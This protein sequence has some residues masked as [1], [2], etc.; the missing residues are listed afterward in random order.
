VSTHRLYSQV[1]KEV[2]GDGRVD[3]QV[4]I[5]GARQHAKDYIGFDMNQ[6]A[7]DTGCVISAIL[8]GAL[9][10]CERLP[11]KREQ[12][13]QVI[14]ESGKAVESNLAGFNAGYRQAQESLDTAN[15]A[16][17]H[18]PKAE[19]QNSYVF[20]TAANQ[21]LQTLLTQVETTLPSAAHEFTVAGIK[22][23]I[24]YQDLDYAIEY[25][26]RL[27]G[28]AQLES[29]QEGQDHTHELT[30][31]MARHLALWMSYEDT[32]RVADLKI[33]EKRF[34]RYKNHVKAK[35]DD[36]THVVEFMHPRLEEI[37][38][39]MP[40]GLG[41]LMLNFG[42]L[43]S[44]VSFFCYER[45]VTTSKLSGFLLLYMTARFK[46][47]RRRT[48]RFK[49]ESE[50]MNN[51]VNLVRRTTETDY[52]SAVEITKCQRLIKGYGDTH[53]RGWANYSSIIASLPAILSGNDPAKVISD[54]RNAALAEESG[55]QLSSQ[56]SAVAS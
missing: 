51:W 48:L 16:T 3:P 12:F 45:K 5:E 23:L 55:S 36:V 28:I 25:V 8:F 29:T 10:G 27:R 4:V 1:E 47:I 46:G 2:L 54:L 24:D 38:D 9:A 42:P 30:K 6:A 37:A 35:Q 21:E 13:E 7:I 15:S 20:P 40:S 22:R 52:K 33:R 31:E 39:T 53:D 50:R 43:K 34:D 44:L 56:L 11:F 18:K 26:D 32:I 49:R 19:T 17:E 14:R 41:N